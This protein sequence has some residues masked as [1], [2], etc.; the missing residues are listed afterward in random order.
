MFKQIRGILFL[1]Y[2]KYNFFKT[3]RFLFEL[4]YSWNMLLEYIL[5]ILLFPVKKCICR[6]YGFPCEEY[7]QNG[8]MCD[9]HRQLKASFCQNYHYVSCSDC[10][11][12]D[13]GLLAHVEFQQR[14]VYEQTYR[15]E[16]DERHQQWM[17][18]L[19]ALQRNHQKP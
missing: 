19:K 10:E 1:L 18:H 11:E 14:V 8:E 3:K 12:V 16:R 17:N 5:S 4:F 2:V 9:D 6:V 15:L 13:L 7:A